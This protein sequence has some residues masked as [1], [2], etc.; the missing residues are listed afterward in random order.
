MNVLETKRVYPAHRYECDWT[1]NGRSCTFCGLLEGGPTH[2]PEA[3]V[4]SRS[5]AVSVGLK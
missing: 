5:F 3:L 1:G 2:S 4:T